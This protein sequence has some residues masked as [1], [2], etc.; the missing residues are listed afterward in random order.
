MA[1]GVGYLN[2]SLP[3]FSSKEHNRNP[4]SVDFPSTDCKRKSDNSTEVKHWKRWPTKK[5][6]TYRR[7]KYKSNERS[8]TTTILGKRKV[9][10]L[11]NLG[12][13]PFSENSLPVPRTICFTAQGPV[14]GKA[15]ESGPK[16]N[17][18]NTG[19]VPSP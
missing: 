14:S 17:L 18:L 2:R 1:T 6:L 15:R 4:T 19:A 16:A 9:N 8:E 12:F 13:F 3:V 10:S 7:S 11:N 5:C